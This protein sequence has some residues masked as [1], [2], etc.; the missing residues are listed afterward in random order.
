MEHLGLVEDVG[1][2]IG[3]HGTCL[4]CCLENVYDAKKKRHAQKHVFDI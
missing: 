4:R 2:R 3:A 1:L